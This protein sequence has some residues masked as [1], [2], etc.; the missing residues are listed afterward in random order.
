MW[1]NSTCHSDLL[2]DYELNVMKV[3]TIVSINYK[4]RVY[5]NMEGP[6]DINNIKDFVN[7]VVS[8]KG[9]KIEYLEEHQVPRKVNCSLLFHGETEPLSA[10]ER[11]MVDKILEEDRIKKEEAKGGKKKKKK[12]K[13]KPL[14]PKKKEIIEDI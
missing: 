6:F 13:E 8:G 12:T 14:K 11:K 4:E 1:V 9:L 7:K 5:S 2:R 10:E 3:P